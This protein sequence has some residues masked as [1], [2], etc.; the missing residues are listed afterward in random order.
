ME[1]EKNDTAKVDDAARKTANCVYKYLFKNAPIRLVT[2]KLESGWKEMTEFHQYPL[3]VL[4]LLGEFAAGTL[5]LVS[6][7]KFEGSVVLQLKGSGLIELLIVEVKNG[8]QIRAMAKIK[9]DVMVPDGI[10]LQELINADN[11][12]RCAMILD[13][14]G[15]K[16]H[17]QPYM[18]VVALQGDTPAEILENYMANS[19]QLQTR[20]VLAADQD[21]IAGM[22]LQRMPE[23]GGEEVRDIDEDAWNRDCQLLATVKE[24]ELL[25]PNSIEELVGKVYWQEELVRL[26]ISAAD[27]YC[28][29]TREKTD[30]M[31][32]SLGRKELEDI[33][34]EEGKVEVRCHFCNKV[35][36][37]SEADVDALFAEEDKAATGKTD[38]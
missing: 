6:T 5:L 11:K 26:A 31:L 19:E 12:G 17:E 3:P 20:L 10:T 25:T 27:F 29:C 22:L 38:A 28:G 8:R 33:L 15:R 24:G 34:R 13:P 7:I 4:R 2:T 30:N 36:T 23:A 21:K 37:Y 16:P 32:R 35:Q 18:G 1:Q 9:S 14:A